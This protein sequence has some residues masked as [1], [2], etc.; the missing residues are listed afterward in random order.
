MAVAA[1]FDLDRTLIA[2]SSAEVFG[3]KLAEVGIATPAI[4][5]QFLLYKLYEK[6]GEDPFTMR[7]ARGAARLFAGRRVADVETAGRL[8]A[9]VLVGRVLP[10][11]RAE[12]ERHRRQGTAVVLADPS[13]L[14]FAVSSMPFTDTSGAWSL[15]VPDLP[16]GP[17]SVTVTNGFGVSPPLPFQVD[18]AQDTDQ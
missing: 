12:I 4:P 7:L 5:G 1:F 15:T 17:T 14:L 2:G 13:G 11:A 6:L 10:H 8:G 3:A 16:V 9:D 18:E